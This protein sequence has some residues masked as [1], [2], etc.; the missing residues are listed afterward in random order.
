[1]IAV[2]AACDGGHHGAIPP[3]PITTTAGSASKPTPAGSG[4]GSGSGSATASVC[5]LADLP[6][7]LVPPGRVVAIGDIHGDLAAARGAL[8]AAHAIDANDKWVGGNLYVVQTG[9]VLDRGDDELKILELLERLDGE[10]RA[11]GGA[12]IQLIGNHELMNAAHD[13]RY[14]TMAGTQD[15]DHDRAG[16]L[17]PG[18]VWAKRFARHDAIVIVG[19]T[20][21]SHAGVIGAWANKVTEANL[22]AR[23]WLD[24]QT[25]Q[26]ASLLTGADSPVWTREIGV[27][28]QT[29]CVLVNAA[30]A[31]LGAKRMVIGHTVQPH[32]NSDCGGRL[33]RIDVGMTRVF[34]GPVE[35]LELREGGQVAAIVGT[36]AE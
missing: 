29:D 22:G 18:G 1:V 14:V 32:I 35:V 28:G 31:T 17:A 3:P 8:R 34:G 10:A 16:E 33:W 2:L 11:A 13:F 24:G 23:C 30:L 7:H 12:L 21:Y 27:V 20:V 19:D 4:S 25:E 9:D 36:R 15:F 6:L 26:V 5:T